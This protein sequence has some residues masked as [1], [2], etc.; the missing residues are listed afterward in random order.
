MVG[1]VEPVHEKDKSV[2]K[3]HFEADFLPRNSPTPVPI[4]QLEICNTS[5]DKSDE[6]EVPE[7]VE[8]IGDREMGAN[9]NNITKD[10]NSE[11]KNR[12]QSTTTAPEMQP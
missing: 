4:T 10:N 6:S 8:E 12:E 11:D 3:D 7:A 5:A 9:K 2:I 1:D